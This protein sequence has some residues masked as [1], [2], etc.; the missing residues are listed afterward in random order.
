MPHTVSSAR[1]DYD[2]VLNK[3]VSTGAM[4]DLPAAAIVCIVTFVIIRGITTGIRFNLVMLLVKLAIILFVIVAGAFYIHPAN[5]RP[6]APYGFG[7]VSLFGTTWGRIG[8]SG[9][10]V[11]V[12]A[13]AALVFYAFIGFDALSAYTDECRNPRRDVPIAILSSVGIITSIYIAMAAVLT[14]M[15]KYSEISGQAPV[16][17]AFRQVGLPWAQTLV[18]VGALVGITGVLLYYAYVGAA[19]SA[20]DG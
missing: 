16:S 1:L 9:Q 13:G 4:C 8:P 17:E 2:H 11:G 18:A 7:G 19:D 14:G 12:F 20:G 15:V 6:F 3:V 5:W 10:A